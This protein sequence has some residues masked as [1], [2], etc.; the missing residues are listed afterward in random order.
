MTRNERIARE[1]EGLDRAELAALREWFLEYD[2]EAWDRQME[3]DVRAGRL[4]ALAESA[5]A[6]HKA[7]KTKAL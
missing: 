5:L 1:I 2:A 4:D 6:A 7:G 3:D